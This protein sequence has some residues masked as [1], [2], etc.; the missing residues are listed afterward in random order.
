M[1]GTDKLLAAIDH[2]DQKIDR[3]NQANDERF[4]RIE[5]ELAEH[6]EGISSHG[7]ALTEHRDQ[8]STHAR[9]LTDHAGF[10]NNIQ[11]TTARAVDLALEA[12]REASRSVGE[13]T[14]IVESA[15][16]MHSASIGATVQSAVKTELAPLV[17]DVDKLK[18]GAKA[19]AETITEQGK[20]L[21]AILVIAQSTAK[22]LGG[23]KLRAVVLV[24]VAAGTI[25]GSGVAGYY[26][27]AGADVTVAAPVPK[28]SPALPSSSE[29][30]P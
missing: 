17:G 9:L 28:P 5:E 16:R 24:C 20:T 10:L 8:L 21:D 7:R 3:H 19:Q 27:H 30:A 13:A 11:T 6:R 23:K 2:I 18:T 29:R 26:A 12:K 14:Q 25:V 22:L 1:D 15:I 4:V